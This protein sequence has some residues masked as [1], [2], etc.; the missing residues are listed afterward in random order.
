MT[1][2]KE[3]LERI[4]S[5]I[6]QGNDALGVGR[7]LL[8]TKLATQ[9]AG[10]GRVAIAWVRCPTKTGGFCPVTIPS[11]VYP[12]SPAIYLSN[13]YTS[14]FFLFYYYFYFSEMIKMP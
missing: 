11:V 8:E 14:P 9:P 13:S 2:F 6:E 4:H 1:D 5:E 10:Q 12:S 7:C 3:K